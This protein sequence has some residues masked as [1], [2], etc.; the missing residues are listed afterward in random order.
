MDSQP[1]ASGNVE[2]IALDSTRF[3]T[4]SCSSFPQLV[5]EEYDRMRAAI[6]E[7]ASRE[8]AGFSQPWLASAP[9]P[10]V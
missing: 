6:R 1:H 2:A 4:P 10:L 7:P 9:V 5:C 3:S 8:A